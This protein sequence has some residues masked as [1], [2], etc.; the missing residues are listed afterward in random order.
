MTRSLEWT[1]FEHILARSVDRLRPSVRTEEAWKRARHLD[2]P[3]LPS[4]CIRRELR[5]IGAWLDLPGTERDP[6]HPWF[7]ERRERL[8]E[9]LR[10]RQSAG[11]Q[12]AQPAPSGR[13]IGRPW[14]GGGREPEVRIQGGKVVAG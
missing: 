9:E 4:G 14:R 6:L 12:N 7:A 11:R 1:P 3:A 2:L 8:L 13:G 5:L 10:R